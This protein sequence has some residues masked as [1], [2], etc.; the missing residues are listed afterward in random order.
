MQAND[1]Y[2]MH[3]TGHLLCNTKIKGYYTPTLRLLE[4]EPM[5]SLSTTQPL[6]I[7]P[8]ISMLEKVRR[9]EYEILD[10]PIVHEYPHANIK[11][12]VQGFKIPD[13]ALPLVFHAPLSCRWVKLYNQKKAEFRYRV[14][15]HKLPVSTY[16]IGDQYIDHDVQL[17]GRVNVGDTLIWD[18]D[19]GT[20]KLGAIWYS[21]IH[22]MEKEIEIEAGKHYYVHYKVVVTTAADEWELSKVE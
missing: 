12:V 5:L 16:S 15:P 21:G 7:K 11:D 22:F 1:Y 2:A 13:A 6:V 14:K 9:K 20:M 17:V 3:L 8:D 18:R 4:H 19:P 10:I